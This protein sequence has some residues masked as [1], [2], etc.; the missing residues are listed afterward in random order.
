MQRRRRIN[1]K[2]DAKFYVTAGR[3]KVG[4]DI[5]YIDAF[6]GRGIFSTTPFEKGDFL[7][8]Y[9]GELI[10]KQECEKRQ[11]LYHSSLK[12][13]MFEFRFNGKL[14]CVDAAKEDGSL[15]RLVNDDHINPNT[16]MK[17]FSVQ[18][19]PHL[20]LFAIR[21]ISPGEE[22]TYNYG[23]SD[24]PWRSKALDEKTNQE[25]PKTTN[26]TS[27]NGTV[28]Q[29]TSDG[30]QTAMIMSAV[31]QT[32]PVLDLVTRVEKDLDEEMPQESPETT[33]SSSTKEVVEQV[34]SE[35]SQIER[36]VSGLNQTSPV[37]DVLPVFGQALDEKTNQEIPKTTNSTSTN[38][39]VE[40]MTSDGSQTAMIMS[41]VSQTRP[42]L[43]LVT[44]VE[45]DLDEE[46]PQES[47][48]TT[49]SSSTKEVVEQVTSEKSQIERTV[50]GLN[51]T[52][53]VLDV[54]PVFGQ[55]LDEK[56][57][58]EIPK[59]TNSTSTNGTVEQMTSDGS[60]TAMIM[61]AVSQTRPVLD[62]VTR[63][64][65]DLDEEM[66]QESPETTNSSSTKEVVE[67]VTSEKSQIERTV[68]G[69][70]QTSPVL[71]VLPVFGQALDEKTNQEIPKTT[72]STS[73]N[74]T[75]EQMTSDGSQTAMI[76]SAVSQTRPVLDLVTRVEKDLDEEMPQ[77]SPE[78]TNSSSTKEVVEQVT[79]EKSQIERTVSGLNQTSPVLD[80][81]PV[82]GQ[83]LDEKTNQEI[84][85]T[86]NS[87]STN[88]TVE[89]MTS[90]GS[91]TAMIMSA[92]SQTRPVLDLVT[93]VEKDLDEE[94]PQESP[95]TTNSSSTKEVVEQVTSEKSQI[96]RTVSGLNQTSPVL[97][98][99]P[100]FGQVSTTNQVS[101]SQLAPAVNI[102]TCLQHSLVCTTVSSLDKCLQCLGPVSSFKWLGYKCRV[103]S[104]VWHKSCIRQITN[105]PDLLRDQQ[106]AEC[107]GDQLSSDQ[108]INRLCSEQEPKSD[109]DEHYSDE[110][111]VP[112]TADEED[113]DEDEDARMPFM[114]R[115]LKAQQP[116]SNAEDTSIAVVP[117]TSKC[118]LPLEDC[119]SSSGVE[120]SDSAH[121]VEQSS[122]DKPEDEEKLQ[123]PESTLLT[124]SSKNYCY[125]C[126]KPQSKISRHLKTHTTHAEI[127]YA[128]SLPEN[129]KERKML[130]EK[131]RNKGNFQHNSA[132]LQDGTG[133]LKVKRRPKVPEMTG[134]FI[135]CMYCKGLFVRKELW[136][137]VRKC[138][139]KPES[140][141]LDKEPGRTKVLGLAAAQESA[142]CQQMSSGVW[143]L[144]SVMKQDEIASVVRN[145]FSIVQFA[146]SLYNRHGQDPTKYEYIRQKLREVG[147]LLLCLRTEFS[148]HN[149]EEAIKPANFQRIVQAVKKVSGFDEERLS[150]QTPSLALKLGHTLRKICDIIHCRALMAED[151]ELI[152]STET[153]K[154][155]HTSKWSELVSHKALSTLSDAKYNKPSTLPFTQD[156]QILHKHLEKTAERAVSDLK[157]EAT[158]QNYAQLAKVTLA[159][160]IVFNRRRAG[161]VSKMRLKSFQE[162]DTTQLHEDVA[163]GLSKIEQKL[164][165]YFRR[166]EI[167]GKRGRKVAVLLTPS[168]VDAL[169]L[170]TSKRTECGVSPTNVF[171]FARPKA[172]SYYRGQDCL[173]IHADMC[174]AK[175]PEHL[176][177][178]QLRKHVAT[179]SQVLNLKNNELDQV[180][181]FL[182]HD[183]RV[184]RDFYRLPVP[185]T[186]L[187]KV[188]KLLLSMEKG[189][190]SGLQG[191]SLD[192]IELEDEIALSD[193]E[194]EDSESESDDNGT[195]FTLH[196]G[197][198]KPVDAASV[199]ALAE[200]AHDTEGSGNDAAQQRD[201]RRITKRTW[202][203]AE[204]AAVMRHFR[205]HISKGKLATKN[206][207]SHCKLVEDP[208]LAQRTVQNIRDFVRNRGT[209][210][211]RQPQK[212]K[213]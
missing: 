54:L 112:D 107:S 24:W 185:T 126:G 82:F 187:A 140:E 87:T 111:Y 81:L 198:I 146:Q 58:Q 11:R 83:A 98:V 145:D 36:T 124:M 38:G 69:L 196:C 159:Q 183:I 128:F 4:L 73:T 10:N 28:E 15:G 30:S 165:N 97:D 41:A 173:R 200:E 47:P 60:Q 106:S 163:M 19:R 154:K 139:C 153:F 207:C 52:S 166:I 123:R 194:A 168:V 67:Q 204:V 68:S 9:R 189:R 46:M 121:G 171:L 191:K 74:G 44:R 211:K 93:R 104:Q 157:E 119:A 91:Q 197:N 64:E 156:V 144:L 122:K 138:S 6:K 35:K 195:T 180:A 61:S 181:D 151:E 176:R 18:G 2:E 16:K 39:T 129:S 169:S 155:L 133:P 160:I 72:N 203:K 179:L 50:S 80:V 177:S 132:V 184:H 53:P 135:H 192:E 141:D 103:C 42:V 120:T 95:E 37:L 63:V 99:L 172:M 31:S 158:T 29:M 105:H 164:C 175:H 127:A 49:N 117:S 1:P 75:V 7:L 188:S 201:S 65:K 78:T 3:D 148:I 20:C 210:A 57:N 143:K 76:M 77:E 152:K 186:Q 167:M 13:F 32:R 108:N 142:S 170:L 125:V 94:M 130:F 162:G 101:A 22:I 137:H 134:K 100:V 86:T 206:E 113:E 161:E 209:A 70:N 205:D 12:V 8:E 45:K 147:R 88:G 150:F 5:Q 118:W 90:D 193:A 136:R 89:Q 79:S 212:H 56:T 115:H 131:M 33:N 84:P 109:D 116:T 178:T 59:T 43:D 25:I 17:Y 40:Q 23:D 51:Q 55:A 208:V 202:S 149:L 199:S 174:G 62:L 102:E 96:E 14:W 92:V 26:S 27:T 213:L 21:D 114:S 190:L 85:K 71:D 48:E 110:D 66:P 34:T 182:G